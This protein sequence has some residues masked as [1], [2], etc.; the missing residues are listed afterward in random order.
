MKGFLKR[1]W[2]LLSINLW[3]YLLFILMMCGLSMYA[4]LTSGFASLYLVIFSAI[5]IMNLFAYDEANRWMG[6]AVAAPN[7]RRVMVDARYFLALCIGAVIMVIEFIMGRPG[8]E[9]TTLALMCGG[10][11]F[12]YTAI[13]LPVFYRFGSVKS[14]I[15]LII[16]MAAFGAAA[17]VMGSMLTKEV[18]QD[19]RFPG[20]PQLTLTLGV[21]ALLISWPISRAIVRNKEF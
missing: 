1:D 20:M 11:F 3:F 21:I 4:K 6:Y 18:V 17:G 2:A 13:V 12:L 19:D 9:S 5:S 14:R 8:R 7:G 15:V 10:V 16:I